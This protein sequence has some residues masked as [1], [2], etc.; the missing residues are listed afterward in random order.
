MSNP[1]KTRFAPRDWTLFRPFDLPP[2]ANGMPPH[3]ER[4]LFFPD[5]IVEL[6]PAA[7]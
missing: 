2:E 3:W 4:I 6:P 5:G 7:A 1:N